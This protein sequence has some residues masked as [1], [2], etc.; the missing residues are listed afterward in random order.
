M[1][2]LRASKCVQIND[3]DLHS[4]SQGSKQAK[5]FKGRRLNNQEAQRPDIGPAVKAGMKGYN[6]Y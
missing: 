5:I 3:L 1:L 2:G 6:I 4:R